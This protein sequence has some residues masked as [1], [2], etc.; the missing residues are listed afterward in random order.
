MLLYLFLTSLAAGL[1]IG[2]HAMLF[3][4]ERTPVSP[5][6]APADISARVSLPTVGGF[7]ALF[8]LTGWIL[9]RSGVESPWIRLSVSMV[10]GVVGVMAVLLL[11]ARWAV[12]AARREVVDER[13]R[14]QGHLARVTDAIAGDEAGTI[15]YEVDGLPHTARARSLDAEPLPAGSEVVIERLEDGIA[16]VEGWARV[17][18]RL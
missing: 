11:I 13:Y 2:V 18:E 3:G 10:L 7:L 15:S 9:S 4:V 8:G 1:A 16:W 12:P 6:S 14:L 17:E 5:H